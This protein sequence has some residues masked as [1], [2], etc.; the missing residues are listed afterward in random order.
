[1]GYNKSFLPEEFLPRVSMPIIKPVTE[2]LMPISKIS[3]SVLPK[4]LRA[5]SICVIA[6]T[7]IEEMIPSVR[8]KRMEPTERVR[9]LFFSKI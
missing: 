6:R 8:D 1:M 9:M 2:K 5:G 7:I 3:S 4:I